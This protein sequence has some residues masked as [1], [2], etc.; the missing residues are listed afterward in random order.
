AELAEHFQ[1]AKILLPD[2]LTIES[3]AVDAARAEE[4]NEMLPV[5]NRGIRHK[6][7][8]LRVVSLVRRLRARDFFP[9]Q[10]AGV[11]VKAEHQELV[12]GQGAAAGG[13]GSSHE[14]AIPPDYRRR[15]AS[16]R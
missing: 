10:L 6:T 9:K 15:M 16:A 7:P 11:P 2:E 14:D 3:V 4:C 13:H 12:L 1:L 5:G 8:V